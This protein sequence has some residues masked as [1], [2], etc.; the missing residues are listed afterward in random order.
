MSYYGYVV[1]FKILGQSCQR[2][3]C[4]LSDKSQN[5]G[6]NCVCLNS[7]YDDGR[8]AQDVF[9]DHLKLC[10]SNNCNYD[11]LWCHSGKACKSFLMTTIFRFNIIDFS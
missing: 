10:D 1:I 6:D 5:C 2:T 7:W 8:S 11:C 3:G 9:G 4:C